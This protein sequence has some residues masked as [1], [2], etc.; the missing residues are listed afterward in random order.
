MKKAVY[1]AP[2]ASMLYLNFSDIL[3]VSGTGDP[4]SKQN[5]IELPKINFPSN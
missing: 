5:P 2:I 4:A 3:T 1:S